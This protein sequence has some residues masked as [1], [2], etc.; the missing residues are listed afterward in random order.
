VVYRRRR[1]DMPAQREEVEAAEREGVRFLFERV[2]QAVAGDTAATGLT[3]APH[4]P[5]GTAPDGSLTEAP[6][7]NLA[8]TVP[9][10]TILVAIGE[11]PDPSILPEG[12]GIE[13][14]ASAAIA[15]DPGTLATGRAGVFAGGDVVSGPKTIIDAVAAGRRA[16]G[17]IHG[18]LAGVADGEAAV[19]AAVR[20]RTATPD[21]LH[22]D[23]APRPRARAP[24]P[25]FEPGSFAATQ[26]GFE[27]QVARAEAARCFRCD[28]VHT[29]G[30]VAVTAPSPVVTTPAV[31]TPVGTPGGPS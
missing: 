17:S 18:Y 28:A 9:A 29:C 26:Q 15:T 5:T 3:V 21:S 20:Y 11:E 27:P 13:V 2:P 7:G 16:A 4:E 8:E 19:M 12:A 1:E 22:L 6:L 14:T 24:L 30:D 25:L 10:R 31:G 23:L